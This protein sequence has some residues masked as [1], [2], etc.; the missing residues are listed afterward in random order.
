MILF[1]CVCSA[2]AVY[3]ADPLDPFLTHVAART[4]AAGSLTSTQIDQIL[5]AG[6]R[7]P[8]ASNRQPWAFTVVRDLTLAQKIVPGV[9]DG[10]ILIVVSSPGN[11]PQSS[12][13][14]DCGLAVESMYLASQALGLGSRIYT[15]P[16]ASVN[17]RFASEL[18]IPSGYSA[19]AIVRVGKL[20]P[21][22]DAI[23]GASSRKNLNSIVNYR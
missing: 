7:A 9:V 4:F 22:S 23:S 11:P 18:G 2:A 1:L 6:V 19:V 14:L 20:G 8:S 21:G 12:A 5:S 16:I 17:Q 3:A 13:F 15:G 10:N